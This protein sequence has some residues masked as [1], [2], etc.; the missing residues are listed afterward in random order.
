MKKGLTQM[1]FVLD[2]S[3]SMSPLTMETIGG[4][5]AMIADQKKEEGDAL[6]TTVLFDH[7]YNMIHDGVNIKEVKDMTT[8]EYM[9]TGMTA[10]LDAVGMTINHVGQKL[11]ALPEEERP[12][13]VL[14]TVVTDG[15]DNSSKEFNWKTV[16]NMIKHQHD[17]YS[18]VFT[19]LGA[20]I[21]VDRVSDNLG[22]DKMLSKRYTASKIGTQK[23]F[24]ATSKAM[25]FAR[26]VSADSLNDAQTMRCMSSVLDEVEDEK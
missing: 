7:R 18:W 21:D 24:S 12:E 3:G 1:V 10:M 16:R 5:N 17:K 22:I 9:P 23:V 6:V 4:Y 14:F 19:F 15:K 13:K 26:D 20:N 8:A 11:A 2:M 25:S